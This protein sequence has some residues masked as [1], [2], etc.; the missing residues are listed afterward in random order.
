MLEHKM[1]LLVIGWRFF[2]WGTL[3]GKG[4]RGITLFTNRKTGKDHSI[5]IWDSEEDAVQD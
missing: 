3:E 4:Y 1:F 2:E 5:S